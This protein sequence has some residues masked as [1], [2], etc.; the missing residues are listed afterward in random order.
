MALKFHALIQ[1]EIIKNT[2]QK[3]DSTL[4]LF[5]RCTSKITALIHLENFII[6]E[7]YR[8]NHHERVIARIETGLESLKLCRPTLRNKRTFDV[9]LDSYMVKKYGK[10][11]SDLVAEIFKETDG[12]ESA[13]R[14]YITLLRLEKYLYLPI[15]PLAPHPITSWVFDRDGALKLAAQIRNGLTDWDL[16]LLGEIAANP[17]FTIAKGELDK[18][19]YNLKNILQ[20]E[21]TDLANYSL[22]PMEF[23]LQK[24]VLNAFQELYRNLIKAKGIDDLEA[25]PKLEI[26]KIQKK[27]RD[28]LASLDERSEFFWGKSIDQLYRQRSPELRRLLSQLADTGQSLHLSPAARKAKLGEKI[29]SNEL[30]RRFIDSMLIGYDICLPNAQ[31]INKR[32]IPGIIANLVQLH[33][34]YS[35]REFSRYME[36]LERARDQDQA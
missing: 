5:R 17:Y 36:K 10:K 27:A 3:P 11:Y 1:G 9:H 31:T 7:A 28:L 35:E 22:L 8:V 30:R 34:K 4:R 21:A 16:S 19:S 26:L 13:D 15:N 33:F 24:L 6:S 25:P 32:P 12:T 14:H 23:R 18:R 29:P 2:H 20:D